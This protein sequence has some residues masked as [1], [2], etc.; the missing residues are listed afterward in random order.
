MQKNELDKSNEYG[1]LFTFHHANNEY[2]T[3]FTFHHANNDNNNE[4]IK[5]TKEIEWKKNIEYTP[6]T[7]TRNA[8][9]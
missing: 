8:Y 6:V 2:G 5:K 4:N 1:T 3:L 9:I 7:A